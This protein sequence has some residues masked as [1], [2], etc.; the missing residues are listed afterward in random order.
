Y[1]FFHDLA[2]TLNARGT[3]LKV[4]YKISI[5]SGT[6]IGLYKAELD[7]M[8]PTDTSTIAVEMAL[9]LPLHFTTK[10]STTMDVYELAKMDVSDKDDLL[11]RSDV[12][13]TE[14]YEKI[15]KS[16]SYFRINYNLINSALGNVAATIEIDD[17][18]SG[19]AGAAQYSGIKKTVQVTV[20][21]ASDDVVDFSPEEIKS[22]LTHFFKPKMTMT[23]AGGQE[24][25]VWRHAVESP[26]VLGISPVITLKL[27]EN[28]PI[29]IK[30]L[31]K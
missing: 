27:D 1:S 23:V 26:T 21:N 20:G 10:A 30:D 5:P 16:I 25:K 15:A 13:K 9:V 7:Q 19:E 14:E 24:L 31:I 28:S 29:D 4:K 8:A 22:V 3:D 11:D 12:S 18:H 2:P 17:S 6:T